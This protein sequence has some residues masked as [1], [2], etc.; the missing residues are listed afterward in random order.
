MA[1]GVAGFF[2]AFLNTVLFMGALVMLFHDNDYLQYVMNGQSALL[3]IASYVGVN[4]VIEM[5][6]ST[7]V[8]GALCGAL[9]KAGLLR[10]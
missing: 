2:A 5:L 3:F 10:R 4:A 6:A 1:G 9:E 8:T 7:I